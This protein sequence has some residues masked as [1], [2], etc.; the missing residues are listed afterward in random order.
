MHITT[1]L[2]SFLVLDSYICHFQDGIS[3]VDHVSTPGVTQRDPLPPSPWKFLAT[4]LLHDKLKTSKLKGL[5]IL[6]IKPKIS[7]P[8]TTYRY[9][10]LQKQTNQFDELHCILSETEWK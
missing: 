2:K 4:P 5:S 1:C 9:V 3:A 6:Y 7:D 10:K 8:S